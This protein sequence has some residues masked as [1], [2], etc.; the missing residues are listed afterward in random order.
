MGV[1]FSRLLQTVKLKRDAFVW[2]DFNDRA[3]G[4]AAILVVLTQILMTLGFG[5]SFVRLLNPFMLIQV[6]LGAL[7]FWVVYSGGVYLVGR[8]LFDASGQYAIYLRITGF[9]YPTLLLS[10]FVVLFVPNA[11]LALILGGAWFVVIVANGLTYTVD[12]SIKMAAVAAVGGY[13][14]IV[15]VQVIF[16]SIWRF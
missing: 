1:V 4:D 6:L 15:I 2:M 10:V 7:F 13:V 8:Y 16:G 5:T 11:L 12:L 3:T 9:A 14:L